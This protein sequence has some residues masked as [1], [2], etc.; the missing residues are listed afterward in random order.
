MGP[1]T[2]GHKMYRKILQ[3]WFKDIKPS[4]WWVKDNDFDQL[5]IDSYAALHASTHQCELYHWRET[6]QGRLAEIIVLD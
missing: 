1:L 4:Q 3:F 5:I 2:G 6:A